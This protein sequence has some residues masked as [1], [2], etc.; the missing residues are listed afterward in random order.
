ML[1]KHPVRHGDAEEQRQIQRDPGKLRTLVDGFLLCDHYL[2]IVGS[3]SS[4]YHASSVFCE[5]ENRESLR[6]RFR[7]QEFVDEVS[8]AIAVWNIP[9]RRE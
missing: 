5:Q 7:G 8:P 4:P 1:Q 6:G 2:G 3:H 9:A